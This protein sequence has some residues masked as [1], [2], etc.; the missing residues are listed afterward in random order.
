LPA[1]AGQLNLI[2]GET[3]LVTAK[4]LV[5]FAIEQGGRDNVTAAILSV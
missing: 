1:I 3:P 4:R 5:Q 2:A